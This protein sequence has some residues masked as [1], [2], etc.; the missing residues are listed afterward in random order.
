MTFQE[1]IKT[2]L[3]EM[4]DLGICS[5]KKSLRACALVD[6]SSEGSSHDETFTE[7]SGMSVS[8]AASLALELC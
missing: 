3:H 7:S 4:A 2:E 1:M 8:E 5:K 6:K